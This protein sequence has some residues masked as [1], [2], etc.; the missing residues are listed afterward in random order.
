MNV[1]AKLERLFQVEKQARGL[2]GRLDSAERFLAEQTKELAAL[3]AKKAALESQVKSLLAAS[4]DAEGESKRLE[5]RMTTIR[6]QMDQAQT[7]KQYQAFLVEMNTLKTDQGKA[8]T[9]ALEAMTKVEDVRKQLAEIEALRATRDQVRKV[10]VTER[11]ARQAE[12]Q[13]RLTELQAQ[14]Q[15]LAADVP[16]DALS[17]LNTLLKNHGDDAMAPVQVEDRKR[18][19]YTCGAC[20]MSI[21]IE[22]VSGLLSKGS[23]TRCG[24]CQCILY[25]DE[26]AQKALEPPEKRR[27][28]A[29]R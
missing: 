11:D 29:G 25:L 6:G 18:H 21:S 12:I 19:E 17:L 14:R 7:T 23:L 15:T 8:E 10:A 26:A 24:S 9:A 5:A 4:G 20:Q 16:A 1:T 22:A 3:D 27:E 28:R 13:T 2:R